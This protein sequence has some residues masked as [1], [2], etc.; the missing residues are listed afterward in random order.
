MNDI[1]Q[2]LFR[3]ILPVCIAF[4]TGTSPKAAPN[5]APNPNTTSPTLPQSNVPQPNIGPNQRT[6]REQP[7]TPEQ[8]TVQSQINTEQLDSTAANI[9][10]TEVDVKPETLNYD[11]S[12][13]TTIYPRIEQL[14]V[15]RGF[16][17]HEAQVITLLSWTKIRTY[18][19]PDAKV[20]HNRPFSDD[21]FFQFAT[22]GFGR[23]D[24]SSRP[25]GATIFLDQTQ[26]KDTTNTHFLTSARR[27]MVKLVMQGF[28]DE[29]GP[30]DV[31]PG[32]IVPF[33]KSLKKKGH[34]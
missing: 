25:R 32:G 27:H 11:R 33:A 17:Q 34:K 30:V 9:L 31:T 28:E 22:T 13:I 20:N 10:E 12:V 19:P 21:Q 7:K 3:L 1:S 15:K 6:E 23:I 26:L 18:N 29:S 4:Q 2:L 24:I 14:L 5:P 8:L 16:T